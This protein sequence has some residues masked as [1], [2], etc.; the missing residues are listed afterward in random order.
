MADLPIPSPEETTPG[1][2]HPAPAAIAKEFESYKALVSRAVDVF[3]DEIRASLWL[4]QPNPDLKGKTPLEVA[5]RSGYDVK[6]L[7]PILVRIEHGI[8]F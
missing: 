1:H 6:V 4:S 8:Y 7:E 5:Q 2:A 3:G